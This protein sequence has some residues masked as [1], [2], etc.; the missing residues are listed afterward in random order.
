MV[1]LKS[2]QEIE[3]MKKSCRLAASV[4]TYID[5]YVKPGISCVEL[6]DLCHEYIVKNKAVPS[7]LNY[8][9]YPKSICTS[10]NSVVCH[11]I[12]DSYVLKEGDIVNLDIT[13]YLEGFHGDTSKTFCV[14]KTSRAARDLVQASYE[15]LW[16]GIRAI[17]RDGYTGDIGEAIQKYIEGKGYSIVRE[18]CGHGIGRTFHEDPA[19]THFGKRGT[20]TKLEPGM[21]F[22]IEPMV[23]LGSAAIEL[24]DDDW[25]VVTKDKKLSAQ[26]EHTIAI[27]EDRVEI[28]TLEENSNDPSFLIL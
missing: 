8:K 17:K 7:P 23:N 22:T 21:V 3:I 18:Y 24:L 25:T 26:F 4:L 1:K 19:I 16:L 15:S 2:N 20:G 6:N 28:L 5:P 9:G 27:R 12:P 13:T 10:V 14:G 11:G